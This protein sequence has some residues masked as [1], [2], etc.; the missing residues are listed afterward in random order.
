MESSPKWFTCGF[1]F[2]TRMGL[3]P[4]HGDNPCPLKVAESEAFRAK[5]EAERAYFER[6][7]FAVLDAGKGLESMMGTIKKAMGVEDEDDD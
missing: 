1:C 2:I 5:I 4:V 7:A 6:Q 3:E